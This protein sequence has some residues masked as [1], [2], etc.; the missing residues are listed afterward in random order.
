[1]PKLSYELTTF[2]EGIVSHPDPEDLTINAATYTL[3]LDSIAP[4]GTLG[5]KKHYRRALKTTEPWTTARIF[6]DQRVGVDDDNPDYTLVYYVPPLGSNGVIHTEAQLG[7]IED[8]YEM[9]ANEETSEDV[10]Y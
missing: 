6:L 4:A 2:N 8:F 5:G 3:N 9:L 1:M 7:F 10:I